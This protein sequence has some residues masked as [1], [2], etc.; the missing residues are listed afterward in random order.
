MGLDVDA[1]CASALPKVLTDIDSLDVL[2]E[3]F[4]KYGV[5]ECSFDSRGNIVSL[6]LHDNIAKQVQANTHVPPIKI[7]MPRDESAAQADINLALKL[8]HFLA[9]SSRDESA[10][11]QH[12]YRQSDIDLALNPPDDVKHPVDDGKA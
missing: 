11:S 10:A 4:V 7:T 1:K 12:Q 2:L 5:T 6:V 9:E 3:K 8:K